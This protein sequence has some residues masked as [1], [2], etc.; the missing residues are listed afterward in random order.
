MILTKSSQVDSG[1]IMPNNS[2]VDPESTLAPLLTNIGI[3]IGLKW[4]SYLRVQLPSAML[5]T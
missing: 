5:P 1:T 2:P 4:Q 3:D